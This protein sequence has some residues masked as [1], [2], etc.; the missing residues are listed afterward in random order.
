MKS[1]WPQFMRLRQR[2]QKAKALTV[3]KI[4]ENREQNEWRDLRQQIESLTTIMKSAM[5][6]ST[7]SKVKG[8]RDHPER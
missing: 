7:K 2:D 6:E 4:V 5:V 3:E 8:F 1:S